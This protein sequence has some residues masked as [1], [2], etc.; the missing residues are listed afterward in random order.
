MDVQIPAEAWG[1]IV[2]GAILSSID[3]NGRDV[4]FKEAIKYLVTPTGNFSG[5]KESPLQMVFDNSILCATRQ[6]I[7]KLFEED[8]RREQIRTVII[9]AFEKA[10]SGEM[11]TKLIDRMANALLDGFKIDRY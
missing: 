3:Q 1:E 2:S 4:L 5:K 7:Q 8:G 9:E 11:R 6:E 10:I